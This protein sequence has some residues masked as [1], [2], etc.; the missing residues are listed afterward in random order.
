MRTRATAYASLPG[1]V[2]LL[3]LSACGPSLR[4]GPR[5]VGA[6]IA[7]G[8]IV[9]AASFLPDEL[10]GGA[11]AQGS[12]FSIFGSDL[13]PPAGANVS[14]FPLSTTLAGVSIEVS[15]SGTTVNAIPVFAGGNQINAI[16]PSDA[17]L[18][19]VLITVIFNGQR[20]PPLR[21]RVVPSAVGIFTL[22]G[23]GQGGGIVTN[24]VSQTN[25]P[26]NGP[27]VSAAPGDFVTV[28]VTGVGPVDGS[29][30]IPPIDA[31]V[32]AT[33]RPANV[34]VGGRKISNVAYAGRSSGF[35]GL[36]QIVIA[37]DDDIPE[38]CA[39]PLLVEIDDIPS[40]IVTMSIRR[41][42][43]QCRDQRTPVADLIGR[44]GRYGGISLA[45][46]TLA[47][48]EDAFALTPEQAE[49][50]SQRLDDFVSRGSV[51]ITN[52]DAARA[53]ELVEHSL[54]P[55]FKTGRTTKRYLALASSPQQTTELAL[56]IGF[57]TFAETSQ[58]QANSLDSTVKVPPLGSC[59]S[60]AIGNL[61]AADQLGGITGGEAPDGIE[62]SARGLDAGES[63]SVEGPKGTRTLDNLDGA[64]LAFL[65]G[66][67]EELEEAPLYLDGGTH[68]VVGPGGNDVGPFRAQIQLAPPVAITNPD[69]LSRIDLDRGVTVRWQGGDPR[70]QLGLLSVGNINTET[71]LTGVT[72]CVVDLGAGSFTIDPPF[73][74]NIPAAPPGD[75]EAEALGFALLAAGPNE[76]GLT[77]FTANGLDEGQITF[78]SAQVVLSTF[79]SS[80][81][82][83]GPSPL[84]P[85]P[86]PPPPGPSPPPSGT[87][88]GVQLNEVLPAMAVAQD[89]LFVRYS[90]GNISGFVG[91]AERSIYLSNNPVISPS[92]D[93]LVNAQTIQLT[94]VNQPFTSGNNALPEGL[95]L[96]KHYVGVVVSVTGDVNPANDASNGVEFEL[97]AN[98][99]PF[100]LSVD[101]E[102]VAPTTV[103][104]G[105][106][107]AVT[108]SVQASGQGTGTYDRSL[109]ISVNQT[110][111]TNDRLINTRLVNVV[112]GFARATSRNNIVPVNLDPGSYFVGLIAETEGDTNPEDNTSNP[113]PIT[114]TNERTP[115]DVAVRA[116]TLTPRSVPAGGLIDVSYT[117]FNTS[118]TVGSY[119]RDVYVSTDNV[120]TTD[121]TLI[122]EG[123]FSVFGGDGNFTARD[124][125]IP[126]S[127]PQ[128]DYFVGVIVESGADTQPGDNASNGLPLT[129]TAA[130]TLTESRSTRTSFEADLPVRELTD[131]S[132]DADNQL[133]D[134]PH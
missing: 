112:E 39:V 47:V 9:N 25:Q 50:M 84:P 130:A 125:A 95:G 91:E 24:F 73:L 43:G 68:T 59:N 13:G 74:R 132:P 19:D 100:D 29:E 89:R 90:V 33:I 49:T 82:P 119:R 55:H 18:G 131:P 10:P 81:V 85:G 23:T 11:I 2:A 37:L 70:T 54:R 120:I 69:E 27:A 98:R 106:P 93:T 21:A 121:D 4:E 56:D 40:N 117:V 83:P 118:R 94:G 30:L 32:I 7:E 60:V 77:L 127:L 105:E 8:G 96:G 51:R 104:A 42:R 6:T 110:I 126:S 116:N 26:L 44:P 108:Y 67:D 133:L 113:L 46:V 12:L 16:M 1:F 28:W 123:S 114:V 65:G 38:G 61:G 79:T 15:G 102:N 48:D 128:G 134:N 20:S 35:P 124:N 14:G 63:L 66:V 129:V 99:P 53:A 87:D 5:Q 45:R 80:F 3:L 92:D 107:I 101:A 36:D 62:E 75:D 22:S 31:G 86:S 78:V 52:P 111:S 41:G 71:D 103:G 76:Q 88:V 109:F 34:F 122:D 17:P 57:A 97:V 64:Y 58:T 115:F 72:T